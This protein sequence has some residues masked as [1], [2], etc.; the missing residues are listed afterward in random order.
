LLENAVAPYE[1]LVFY[2]NICLI[3]KTV[4]SITSSFPKVHFRR[5]SQMNDAAR[6]A[7]QNI[8]EGYRRDTLGEF[9]RSIKI[10][11]A[12]LDE[13]EGDIDDCYE[14]GLITKEK[15]NEIKDL[16][17]KTQYQI[18]RYIDSLL[19]LEKEGKWKSRFKSNR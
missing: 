7:K 11:M 4:F 8:R 2:Q 10:S 9:I 13:L 19:K 14:D 15:Y 5:V 6:S 16:M 12:S 18:D 1:K 17:G 3:R